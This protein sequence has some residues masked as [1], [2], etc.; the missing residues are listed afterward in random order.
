MDITHTTNQL[1]VLNKFKIRLEKERF[2]N[3]QASVYYNKQ[4]SLFIIP[5]IILTGISSI[6]SFLSTSDIIPDNTRSGFAISVGILTAGATII[7]SISSS[8]GFQAKR[9]AFQ[10]STD[11][12][13]NLITKLEFEIYNPNE[14]FIEFCN[15]LENE[16]LKIK[17][18]CKYLP[19]LS[20]Y[21]LYDNEMIRR[22][23]IKDNNT[24]NSCNS[25]NSFIL[26]KNKNN[27]DNTIIND[28]VNDQNALRINS[29]VIIQDLTSPHIFAI[30][31]GDALTM[32]GGH[33]T[34]LEPNAEDLASKIQQLIQH[35]KR[36]EVLEK[37]RNSP[38]TIHP[39]DNVAHG[40]YELLTKINLETLPARYT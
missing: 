30:K 10:K 4:S 40:Y 23:K 5:G 38:K 28:F 17:T 31:P 14:E 37:L 33:G 7:Q 13:D 22:Q 1:N 11:S 20:I 8:F 3:N 15:I 34:V 25:C 19:P 12:Y 9:D 26:N 32:M 35:L 6:T 29:A 18:D 24:N 2:I 27:N 36:E 21:K 39:W 16:I